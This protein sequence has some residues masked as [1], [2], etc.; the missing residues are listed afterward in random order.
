[1]STTSPGEQDYD[2]GRT[3]NELRPLLSPTYELCRWVEGLSDADRAVVFWLFVFL[4]G[5]AE[6]RVYQRETPE[7]CNHWWHR[8]LLDDRVVRDLVTNPL[9]S[10]P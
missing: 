2:I 9:L 8:D 5:V 10:P 4:F 7:H 1:M 3:R 6:G